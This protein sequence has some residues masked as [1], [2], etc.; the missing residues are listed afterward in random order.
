MQPMLGGEREQLQ[1][2]LGAPQPPG[3][4]RDRAAGDPGIE[5]AEQPQR[6]ACFRGPCNFPLGLHDSL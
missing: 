3:A 2:R 5:A 1:Q 6:E 4:V